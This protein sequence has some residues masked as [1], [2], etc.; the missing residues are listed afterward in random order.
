[1]NQESLIEFPC[2]FAVKVMGEN[3]DDFAPLILDIAKRHF[4]PID[5]SACSARS[6]SNQRFVAVTVRVPAK[7]QEQLDGFYGELTTNDRVIMAL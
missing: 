2:E 7:N 6:S 4:G 3:S 1:M 5:D